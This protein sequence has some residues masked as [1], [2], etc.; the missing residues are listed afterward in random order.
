METVPKRAAIVRANQYMGSHGNFL[1]AYV[2]HSVS[3]A[4]ELPEY[5]RRWERRRQLHIQK[6]GER[7]L[8]EVSR[9][10]ELFHEG[11]TIVTMIISVAPLSNTSE[12]QLIFENAKSDNAT[13]KPN[14]NLDLFY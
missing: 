10:F 13:L 8:N 12:G 5:A 14:R 1:I 6:L 2:W 9:P 4:E 7:K 11:P 3:N